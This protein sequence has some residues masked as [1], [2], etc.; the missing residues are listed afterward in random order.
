[1]IRSFMPSHGP[2]EPQATQRIRHAPERCR[3]ALLSSKIST[4]LQALAT[5]G[6]PR[7]Q[8]GINCRR[9]TVPRSFSALR[10][11]QVSAAIRERAVV[12]LTLLFPVRA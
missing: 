2:P 6:V 5:P 10:P 12:C 1:M 7:F 11:T 4:K 3:A 8:N 9:D